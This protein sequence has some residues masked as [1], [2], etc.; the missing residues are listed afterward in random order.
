MVTIA[1]PAPL[2][3]HP[4]QR[5]LATEKRALDVDAD[6]PVPVFLGDGL[7][8]AP[9]MDAGGEEGRVDVAVDG[10]DHGFHRLAVRHVHRDGFRAAARGGDFVDGPAEPGGVDVGGVDRHPPGEALRGGARDPAGGAG[11]QNVTH[12]AAPRSSA[13]RR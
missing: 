3:P 4:A 12:A 7:G 13:G 9:D 10:R 11:D 8:G 2:R 1:P 5:R 6:H